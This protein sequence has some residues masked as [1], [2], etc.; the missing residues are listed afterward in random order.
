MWCI[1][2]RFSKYCSCSAHLLGS[3]SIANVVH[4]CQV[5]IAAPLKYGR[6]MFLAGCALTYYVVCFLVR[7]NRAI[8]PSHVLLR[9]PLSIGRIATRQLAG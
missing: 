1:F 4:I 3:V 6:R 2:V 8:F 5:L 7:L 9:Q